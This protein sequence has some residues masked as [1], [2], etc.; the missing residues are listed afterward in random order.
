VAL[1]K[2]LQRPDAVVEH[3][4]P[5]V[6]I[7]K[8]PTQRTSGRAW[9]ASNVPICVEQMLEWDVEQAFIPDDGLRVKIPK[10]WQAVSADLDDVT[11]GPFNLYKF[12]MIANADI[13]VNSCLIQLLHQPPSH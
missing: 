8:S 3:L 9:G 5:W 11:G 7:S 13:Y 1:P 6:C 12:A 10:S 4:S 2:M